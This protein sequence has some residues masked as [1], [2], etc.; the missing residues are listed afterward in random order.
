MNQGKISPL[1]TSEK[2]QSR[3]HFTKHPTLHRVPARS[4]ESITKLSLILKDSFRGLDV[5]EKFLKANFS[6]I[7]NTMDILFS[8]LSIAEDGFESYYKGEL[9]NLDQL[10]NTTDTALNQS[11]EKKNQII[12]NARDEAKKS[13]KVLSDKLQQSTNIIQKKINKMGQN[14]MV[15]FIAITN[16]STTNH[17]NNFKVHQDM[18]DV[19]AMDLKM[20]KDLILKTRKKLVKKVEK[21]WR[22]RLFFLWRHLSD[23]IRNIG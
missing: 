22:K 3:L 12:E 21:T 2:F 23:A 5:E 9:R 15:A 19:N 14:N 10:F 11:E 6:R 4:L 17:E 13:R 8:Q 20:C 16:L 7:Q 18:I 1:A